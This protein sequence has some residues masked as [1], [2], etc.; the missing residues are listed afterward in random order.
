MTRR[1]ALITE[2]IA[3]YRIPVFNALARQSGLDLHVIF[4]AET[5]ETLRQWAV[6]KEEISFSYEIL[7]SWRWRPGGHTL[8]LN[9]GLGP[10]LDKFQPEVII[11]GGYSYLAS[12]QALQWARKRDADFVLWTESNA[13]DTRKKRTWVEWLKKYFVRHCDRFVVPGKASYDYLRLLESPAESIWTAPN[14]VDNEWF[15]KQADKVRRSAAEFRQKMNLPSRFFLFVGR[16]VPEKGVFDLLA[17]YAKLKVDLRSK[18]GLV[19]AGDGSLR[20]ELTQKIKEINPGEVCLTGFAQREDLACLYAL[21]D[22]LVLPTH[23]DPWGLVV[24]EAMACGLPV[25][26]TGV[27]GCSS[28]LVQ[29]GWNGH[30]VPPHDAEKLGVAIES[31]LE[32]PELCHQMGAHSLERIQFNSPE[33]CAQGLAAAAIATASEVQ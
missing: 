25:I 18:V 26:V 19:F 23:S 16:L 3:P 24:N 28:D 31:L 21:A 32:N 30:V 15:A 14:A 7:Q 1:L 4:L 12:W 27:A 29:N 8:L 13:F 5:D 10:A 2:I 11:C 20:E 22:F 9:R 17:A 33:A 6:Y